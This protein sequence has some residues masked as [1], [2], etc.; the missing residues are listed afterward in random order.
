MI[1]LTLKL[2]F[3]DEM[4]KVHLCVLQRLL[5]PVIS[6]SVMTAGGNK[7]WYMPADSK[8]VLLAIW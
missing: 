8:Y 4:Q 6:Y 1:S 7:Y 2:Q 3:S 5:T